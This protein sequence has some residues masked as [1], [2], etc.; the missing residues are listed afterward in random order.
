M[1]RQIFLFIFFAIF[2]L[3]CSAKQAKENSSFVRIENG[4]FLWNDKPYYYV[5]ANFWYGAIL[6]SEGEG[7]NRE[8]LHKELDYLKSIG[9]SNLRVLVGSDSTKV[10]FA[11]YIRDIIIIGCSSAKGSRW[12]Q[13]SRYMLWVSPFVG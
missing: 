4:Q 1:V 8:R 9:V 2:Y 10:L 11:N 3:G 13:K 7:G 5:G 12:I 6:A